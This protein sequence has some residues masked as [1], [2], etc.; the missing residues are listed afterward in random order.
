[1]NKKERERLKREIEKREE[2]APS[3]SEHRQERIKVLWDLD[4]HRPKTAKDP[5]K[6]KIK[7][8][9]LKAQKLKQL[10]DSIRE[11]VED[12]HLADRLRDLVELAGLQDREIEYLMEVRRD[13]ERIHVY[14]PDQLENL[15]GASIHAEAEEF[16]KSGAIKLPQRTPKQQHEWK[17]RRRDRWVGVGV[18]EYEFGGA[19]EAELRKG[20]LL[21]TPTPIQSGRAL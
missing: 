14:Y 15:H 21:V 18:I 4:E 13:W 12:E 1:V 19:R 8:Q 7:G 20:S 5:K 3:E 9:E 2:K 10:L 17:R 6:K 11:K 16:F